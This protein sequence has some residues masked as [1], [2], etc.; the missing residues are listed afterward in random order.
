MALVLKDVR[1]IVKAHGLS[2]GDSDPVFLNFATNKA[3][4]RGAVNTRLGK[5]CAANDLP[6]Q[7]THMFRTNLRGWGRFMK[8]YEGCAQYE[9]LVEIQ[10]GHK[11]KGKTALAYSAQDY[12]WPARCK[13]METYDKF[14]N[15]APTDD[16]P[17]SDA[18]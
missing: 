12:D 10:L 2:D 14:W 15:T 6:R 8:K 9:D 11:V 18:K 16:T 3:Y 1:Q 7:T 5:I 13:M 17:F 4:T